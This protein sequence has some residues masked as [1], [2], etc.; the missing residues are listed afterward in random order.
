MIKL[1]L[2]IFIAVTVT[3]FIM[4]VFYGGQLGRIKEEILQQE[5]NIKNRI[6]KD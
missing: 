1:I 5:E 4:A 6:K 3:M 2:V